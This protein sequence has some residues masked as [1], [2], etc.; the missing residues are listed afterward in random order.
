[1]NPE[2]LERLMIDHAAGELPPDVE[3]LLAAHILQNPA[4]RQ[5][6]VE[7][8]ET[9][10]LARRVLAEQP[11]VALPMVRSSTPVLNWAWRLAACFVGGLLLGIFCMRGGQAPPRIIASI[12]SQPAAAAVTTTEESGIWSA[13]RLRAGRSA[14]SAKAENRI[15]WKSPVRKPEIF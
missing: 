15:I 8:A 14:V 7:I 11:A 12:P 1:M 10:G 3:D 9:L 4:A 2:I 13:R 6:A 5:E